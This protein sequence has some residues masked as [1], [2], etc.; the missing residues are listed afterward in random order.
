MPV[1]ARGVCAPTVNASSRE[2][3]HTFSRMTCPRGATSSSTSFRPSARRTM[4]RRCCSRCQS[5]ARRSMRRGNRRDQPRSLRAVDQVRVRPSVAVVV[6]K[7]LIADPDVV[8]SDLGDRARV[9]DGHGR[10]RRAREV[11]HVIEDGV[12]EVL[13]RLPGEAAGAP[14]ARDA[15]RRRRAARAALADIHQVRAGHPILGRAV[16]DD[17]GQ[18]PKARRAR[19]GPRARIARLAQRPSSRCSSGTWSRRRSRWRS[20]SLGRRA[21]RCRPGRTTEP[22][23]DVDVGQSVQLVPSSCAVTISVTN[24]FAIVLYSPTVRPR[25]CTRSRCR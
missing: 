4:G 15:G 11:E 2:G 3:A 14:A 18:G 1:L 6:T 7:L 10:P 22:R 12:P 25:P 8:R 19:V 17:R 16:V 20:R 13:R 24:P 5:R 21:D 23:V 9:G